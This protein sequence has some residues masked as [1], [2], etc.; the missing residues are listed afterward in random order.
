MLISQ[1]VNIT[2]G[3][4]LD[5]RAFVPGYCVHTVGT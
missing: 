3:F 1:F 2:Q 5:A 4:T